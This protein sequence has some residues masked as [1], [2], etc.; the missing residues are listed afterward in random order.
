[1]KNFS[2]L[3]IKYL[4]FVVALGLLFVQTD[5][6][7]AEKG[8]NS[9]QRTKRL[10]SNGKAKKVGDRTQIDFEGMDITGS[11]RT[12]LGSMINQNKSV[13]D[14]DFVKIRLLWHNEM[15]NSTQ[16]LNSHKN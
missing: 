14:Y 6:S 7:I 9:K 8:K 2:I 10:K 4:F 16:M 15:I 11:R 3:K 13:K 5:R 12:P 1:M